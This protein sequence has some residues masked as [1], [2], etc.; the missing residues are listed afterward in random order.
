M[1]ENNIV[2]FIIT[3]GC[4]KI[5]AEKFLDAVK[6]LQSRINAMVV[7]DE[8]KRCIVSKLLCKLMTNW[9][10]QLL[11]PVKTPFKMHK[12]TVD[13][14]YTA[15]HLT[16]QRR[17]IGIYDEEF[18]S[19]WANRIM[20]EVFLCD[21][22][23]FKWHHKSVLFSRS[24]INCAKGYGISGMART[25]KREFLPIPSYGCFEDVLH[26]SIKAKDLQR[27]EI[28]NASIKVA[29]WIAKTFQEN[30]YVHHSHLTSEHN[31]N[32]HA[33]WRVGGGP[34]LVLLVPLL[35]ASMRKQGELEVALMTYNG[36]KTGL[37]SPCNPSSVDINSFRN[38]FAD[39]MPFI[40][41]RYTKLL[42]KYKCKY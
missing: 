11:A 24:S 40:I 4:Q 13:I 39:R 35:L 16:M 37:F 5:S 1:R 9:T 34:L 27:H 12:S 2:E 14:D 21:S 32:L 41:E 20:E 19:T 25:T 15:A 3:L 31:K 22:T 36:K 33:Q 18:L 30:Q 8:S 17:D 23:S 28:F 6:N 29:I 10:W 42:S 26:I 38:E 7:P